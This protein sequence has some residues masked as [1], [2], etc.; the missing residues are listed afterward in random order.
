[1]KSERLC[2]IALVLA[3]LSGLYSAPA[4]AQ[5]LGRMSERTFYVTLV[6]G[7]DEVSKK[8]VVILRRRMSVPHD[9][10]LVDL[11]RASP[12]D[13]GAALEALEHLK[14]QDGDSVKNELRTAPTSPLSRAFRD[15]EDSRLRSYLS[16]LT[17]APVQN[18]PG[19]GWG[20]TMALTVPRAAFA[21]KLEPGA[22]K[23]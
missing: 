3:M 14:A 12:A 6:A 22:S 17:A 21:D 23:R 18:V 13:L 5:D 10:I 11:K 7:T 16:Y 4:S 9:I 15:G 8:P 1:M 2:S 20:N 19:I